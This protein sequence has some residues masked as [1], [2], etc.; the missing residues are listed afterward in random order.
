MPENLGCAE[1][2]GLLANIENRARIVCKH[3]SVGSIGYDVVFGFAGDEVDET[4]FVFAAAHGVHAVSNY[5][6]VGAD[7]DFAHVEVVVSFGEFVDIEQHL[8][9]GVGAVVTAA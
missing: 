4:D 3:Q 1:S 7:A 8:L 6:V 9:S 5:L 2:V